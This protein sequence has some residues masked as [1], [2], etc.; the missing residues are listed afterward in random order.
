M[1][2]WINKSWYVEFITYFLVTNELSHVYFS[3]LRYTWRALLKLTITKT[4]TRKYL[5]IN[6]QPIKTKIHSQ[7]KIHMKN[8]HKIEKYKKLNMME[9][10]TDMSIDKCK[11]QNMA[12]YKIDMNIIKYKNWSWRSTK[13]IWTLRI[14][15]TGHERAQNRHKHY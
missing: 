12:D 2:L 1:S 9:H 4:W 13:Q 5:R 15:K 8:I 7:I 10:K 3:W 11:K 14:Q 6:T